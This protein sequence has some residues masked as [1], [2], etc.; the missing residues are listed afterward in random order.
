MKF[1]LDTNICIYYLNGTSRSVV[2]RLGNTPFDEVAI[3]S[4]VVAELLY[5]V[6]KG[7][8]QQYNLQIVNAFL[9]YHKIIAFNE[10][11]ARIY[12]TIRSELEHSGNIIG[13][14]DLVIAA[15]AMAHDAV[16]IT[17]NTKEFS[18]IAQLKID[19]WV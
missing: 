5:G 17:H 12:G 8:R 15:T 18:R 14:N 9:S 11:A 3:P 1:C 6:A 2:E 16:L 4:M 13:A 10:N 19:D 7:T